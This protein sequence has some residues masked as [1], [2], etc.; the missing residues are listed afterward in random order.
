MRLADAIGGQ[1]APPP[2]APQVSVIMHLTGSENVAVSSIRA[3]IGC[4]NELPSAEY[5]FIDDRPPFSPSAGNGSS[6]LL[7]ELHMTFGIQY[8]L[9]RT[10]VTVGYTHALTLMAARATGKYLLFLSPSVLLC[11]G[12]LTALYGTFINQGDVGLVGSKF[13]RPSGSEVVRDA[14]VFSDG[15]IT[16]APGRDS[17][18][19]YLRDV[20][21]VSLSLAMVLRAAWVTG[22]QFDLRYAPRSYEDIDLAFNVRKS[23]YRVL[24][25]P[26]AVGYLIRPTTRCKNHGY[27]DP[28][29]SRSGQVCRTARR[30]KNL[31][32]AKW[33][34]QLR[35]QMPAWPCPINASIA[36]CGGV[37]RAVHSHLA[38]TRAY[39]YRVLWVDK[40]LPEPD[41]DSGSVRTAT[42]LKILLAMRCHVSIVA[43]YTAYGNYRQEEYYS[44][45][46][47][48]LGVEV[49]PS[50]GDIRDGRI[51][52]APFDLIMIARRDVFYKTKNVIDW[53]KNVSRETVMRG[54][55]VTNGFHADVPVVF[56]TVDL[57]F[58][59]ERMQNKLFESQPPAVIEAIFGKAGKYMKPNEQKDQKHLKEELDFIEQ[60]DVVVVVSESE[61][62]DVQTELRANSRSTHERIAV[63]SNAHVHSEPT[64]T[65]LKYRAGIVFVGNFDHLPNIDAV[66]WFSKEVFPILMQDPRARADPGFVFHIIGAKVSASQQQGPPDSID[67]LN[68]SRIDGQQRILAHGHVPDLLPL[69]RKTRLSVAPLRWGAGV[70]GKINT[71]HQLGIPVVCTTI[72][73]SGMHAVNG[74][75]VL[76]ADDPQRFAAMVLQ[77]YYDEPTWNRLVAGGLELQERYFSASAAAVGLGRMM[78]MLSRN[79]TPLNEKSEAQDGHHRLCLDMRAAGLHKEAQRHGCWWYSTN[80]RGG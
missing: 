50:W 11:R 13:L 49:I 4:A 26:F 62:N 7:D 71:A 69:Y 21:A 42:L 28:F 9:L 37:G 55:Q 44:N 10:P 63:I 34:T 56:D 18:G 57:H 53:F 68:K 17:A 15:G 79:G 43:S 73:A 48:N 74:S 30:G 29:P 39:T 35:G 14:S 3:L 27:E 22:N 8:E 72:A 54:G 66:V 32:E 19:D 36:Q 77:A 2:D 59:R 16:A 45:Y 25:Q 60:S 6:S 38:I 67:A 46:M 41:R 52:R 33:G 40:F 61:Q 80:H 78:T 47:R 70:K 12:T 64:S 31:F 24:Y 75:H 51:M 23:G 58:V 20:D 5:L 65:L 1:R 76:T